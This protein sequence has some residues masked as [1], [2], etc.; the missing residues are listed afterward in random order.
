MKKINLILLSLS[1]LSICVVGCGE[2]WNSNAMEDT[3]WLKEFNLENR[4]LVPTG[5]NE[6]FILEPGFQLVL[7]KKNE[8]LAI[9]VL[10][11]TRERQILADRSRQASEI[12]DYPVEEIFRLIMGESRQVQ[13]KVRDELGMSGPCC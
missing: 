7:E 5:R 4:S 1:T 12:G 8:R 9:T 13:I 10:D 11:E 2:S 6:F 3:S